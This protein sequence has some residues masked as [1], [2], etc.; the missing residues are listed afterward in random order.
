MP[1]HSRVK[2][3]KWTGSVSPGQRDLE[4]QPVQAL[5]LPDKIPPNVHT[6]FVGVNPGVRSARIGHYFGGASNYFWKLLHNSGLWPDELTTF[7]DDSVV[8]G[9]FGFTD[10][11]KRPTPGI[12][13]LTK[14]DFA[15]SRIRISR[16]VRRH[17]PKTVVFVSKRAVRAF[18]GS[19]STPVRY[20]KQDWEIGRI[21]VFVVPST[22]GASLADTSYRSKLHWFKE[23]RQHIESYWQSNYSPNFSSGGRPGSRESSRS[24]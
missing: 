16:L 10:T 12:A 19:N 24:T 17:K 1:K 3:K 9:G 7:D 8:K 11:C 6:L 20:G 14:G 2:R 23:L 4:G 22:S 13:T 5:W 18:L 15:E 21:P